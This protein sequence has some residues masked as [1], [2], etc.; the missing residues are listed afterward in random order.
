M[1]EKIR[2]NPQSKQEQL[3]LYMNYLAIM[4]A[5]FLPISSLIRATI[6]SLILILFMYRRN[7]WHYLKISLSNP[8]TLA[9]LLYFFM[10]VVWL[11]GTENFS[12]ALRMIKFAE[13]ALI[14]LL[15]YT[16]VSKE[17]TSKIIIAFL[18]SIFMAEI[19]SYGIWF[20]ILPIELQFFN[21]TIYKAISEYEPVIFLDH[22]RYTVTLSFVI[23]ILV[24]Q[25][26][27]AKVSITYRTVTSIFIITASINLFLMGGRI[28]YIT[29]I[30]LLIFTT[31]YKFKSKSI[32]PLTI[33]ILFISTT[34]VFSYYNSPTFKHR[35]E[36]T[37]NTIHKLSINQNDTSTSFGIRLGLWRSALPT[38][39]ENFFFGVGTGDH[40]D[41]TKQ[42]IP[43]NE[44]NIKKF[45]HLH[46]Q[47]LEIWTQFG[48]IGILIFLNIFFQIYKYKIND[49]QNI[50]IKY[51]LLLTIIIALMTSGFGNRY[52]L[53]L[54][55]VIIVALT[56]EKSLFVNKSH[57]SKIKEFTSY[58]VIL[59]IIIVTR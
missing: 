14:P 53:P 59:L 48:L 11:F 3:T 12:H 19:I 51:A 32:I 52:Y 55:A 30:V 36:Y 20:H 16:F 44:E 17:F 2:N 25:L 21:I 24:Y 28:G 23:S 49:K 10:H 31:F 13:Y 6:F 40:M 56:T 38:I 9:F 47:Y 7:Y 4:Y 43:K 26:L 41:D 42:N 1:I 39:K 18:L 34:L 27:S 37:L 29:F 46:N 22:Y 35:I 33:T 58:F 45:R 54:F 57:H 50:F 15:F 8:I 5:F